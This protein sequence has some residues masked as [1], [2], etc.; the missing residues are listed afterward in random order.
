[1]AGWRAASSTCWPAL[2]APGK[3]TIAMSIAAT[4]SAGVRWPDGTAGEHGDVLI[5]SGEDG[6][7]DTLLPRLLVAGGHPERVHFV[8]GITEHGKARP[9]D[10]ATD[11][12]A[13]VKAARQLPNLK[14]II[15][16][17]V[18]AAVSGDSHK[19]TETRRGLQPVVDLAGATRLL[20]AGHHAPVKEHERPGTAGACCGL[21]CLR[22]RRARRAG[23]RQACRHRGTAATGAGKEPTSARIAAALPTPCSAPLVPGPRLHRPARRLGRAA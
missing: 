7:A 14:L 19:N 17:P 9:F 18:V 6:V 16:D 20:P 10:P 15:L 1:M 22:R 13:L 4:V 8:D 2:L 3:T 12:P 11:M 21:Y 23:D 5:W